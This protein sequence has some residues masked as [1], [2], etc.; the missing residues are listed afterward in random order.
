MILSFSVLKLI[1]VYFDF[2]YISYRMMDVQVDPEME[3]AIQRKL[4][5]SLLNFGI[6]SY[7]SL[8]TY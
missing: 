4:D 5:I 1:K 7:T 6:N 8:Q 3:L 2:K